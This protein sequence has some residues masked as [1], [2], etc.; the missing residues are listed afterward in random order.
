MGDKVKVAMIGTGRMANLVH[1]PSLASFHDV[2][3]AAVCDVYPASLHT[4]ADEY[5]I[6]KRY[7][8]YKMMIEEVQ[9][10][11]VYAIGQPHI[12]YDVW[13]W[14][15]TRGI[16]LYIEKPLGITVHQARSLAHAAE[17]NGCITQVSFQRRSS[18]MVTRLREECLKRGPITHA[19]CRFYKSEIQPFLGARDRMMDDTVH[20]IDT[21]RWMCGGEAA[22]IES[23]TKRVQVPD[24]NFISATIHFDNGSTGYLINSWSSGRRIFA[25]EMHAPNI[26]VEAEHETK[27]Y[28][29]ADGDTAGVEYDAREMAGG[30]ELFQFGGFQAK[31]REFIN[32]LKAGKLPS[33]HF[34]DAVK[35][36]EIAEVI[37]AQALLDGR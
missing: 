29:Y 22:K 9:P 30:G 35:T 12:M 4:T 27:G 20:S 28:L 17:K 31:H 6:A 33:S 15:L 18:P 23:T 1:F 21:L 7:T 3:I 24:I 8:D 36:M 14:C 13:M 11:A 37:L 34:G 26:C 5:G 16:H 25:V 10:D 19:V 2:E 32:C